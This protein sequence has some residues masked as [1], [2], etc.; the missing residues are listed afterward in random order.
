MANINTNNHCEGD[1]NHFDNKKYYEFI[2]GNLKKIL[3][4]SYEST[5]K[6]IIETN[7]NQILTNI[8]T[9]MSRYI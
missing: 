4:E 7:T 1:L 6:K 3:D 2:Q 5:F 9:K 8:H